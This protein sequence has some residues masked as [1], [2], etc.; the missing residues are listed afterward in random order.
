MVIKPS[1]NQLQFTGCCTLKSDRFITLIL[2]KNCLSCQLKRSLG[3]WF[4][5]S[6]RQIRPPVHSLP[7]L[8]SHSRW[9]TL[10]ALPDQN[11]LVRR[12]L[13]GFR[14]DLQ[15]TTTNLPSTYVPANTNNNLFTKNNSNNIS[16]FR[17]L[18]EIATDN[19][20]PEIMSSRLTQQP[21]QSHL[22]QATALRRSIGA[23]TRSW[24]HLG[25]KR[26]ITSANLSET[27][28][29]RMATNAQAAAARARISNSRY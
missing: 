6:F 28:Q 11:R 24:N 19:N 1:T 18:D 16:T 4:I 25:S 15:T 20:L 5:F 7:R 26:P 9:Y 14:P 12:D 8:T 23:G 21:Q 27:L 29:V 10:L 3:L 22:N 2:L 17:A 13:R